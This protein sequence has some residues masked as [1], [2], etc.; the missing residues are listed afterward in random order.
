MTSFDNVV[1]LAVLC[2]IGYI[3]YAKFVQKKDILG[4][5]KEGTHKAFGRDDGVFGKSK[6]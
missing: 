1:G 5:L 2:G 4:S 3:I 6:L